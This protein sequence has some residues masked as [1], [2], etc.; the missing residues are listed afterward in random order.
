MKLHPGLTWRIFRV[1][2][3]EDINDVI[4]YFSGCLCKQSVCVNMKIIW[5]L[6]DMNCIFSCLK[7]YFTR[8]LCSFIKI[9]CFWP[10]GSKIHICVLLCNIPYENVNCIM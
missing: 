4:F 1:L 3:S 9:I 5:W 8:L 10:L 7:Q 6:E 2:T